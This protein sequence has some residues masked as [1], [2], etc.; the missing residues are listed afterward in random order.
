MLWVALIAIAFVAGLLSAVVGFGGAALMLPGLNE[1][2]GPR[3][4]VVALTI[5][6]IVSNASRVW[7]N[8]RDLD[9]SALGWYVAGAVPLTIVGGLVFA[10]TPLRHMDWV[11]GAVLLVLVIGRRVLAQRER[12]L[13]RRALVPVGAATGLVSTLA[14][15]AGPLVA[16]FFLAVGLTRG[17]FIGTEAA[18]ALTVHLVKMPVYGIGGAVS[19][20][21]VLAGLALAPA[22]IAGAWLGKRVLDKVSQNAFT[23]IVE[24]ALVIAAVRM[25]VMAA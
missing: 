6:Q 3:D 13:S 15:T 20:R 25:L 16:P 11:L 4:A 23:I 5:A 19:T 24:V 2:V 7:I 21:A 10:A 14:G 22:L 1:A 17:A 8:R 12:H 18:A 9:R